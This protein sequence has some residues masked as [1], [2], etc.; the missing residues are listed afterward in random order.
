MD[1]NRLIGM[2]ETQDT[3]AAQGRGGRSPRWGWA[4]GWLALMALGIALV[5][6][7]AG[8]SPNLFT[9]SAVPTDRLVF[10]SLGD[11]KTF[12]PVMSNESPNVFSYITRGLTTQNGITGEVEPELAE[13]WDITNDGRT[14]TFTL[15]P[16]LRWSD[17][18][19]LTAE[20]VVFT[21]N[22][23]IF[24]EEIPTSSRDVL[25]IGTQ[26]LLPTV[27]QVGD[28]QVQFTLP[29]PF[30][31]FL[32][33]TG[34]DILPA[35][36]LRPTLEERD[37]DGNLR[38][39]STWGTSTPPEQVV[40][41]GPYKLLRYIPSERIIFERNPEYWR[42]GPDGSDQPYIQQL[43]WQIIESTDNALL[44]FRSGG[45]DLTGVTPDSFALLKREEERGNFTIYNGGPAT[46]TLFMAFNLNRASRNGVPLVDPIKSRWF[47][48]V[49]FRQ[50]VSYAINRDALINNVYQGL[51]EPQT[52]PISVQS[53][54]YAGPED[55]IRTYEH[56]VEK[57]R[58]LLEGDGFQWNAAG[59]LLD[60]QGNRV[61]FTLITNAGNKIRE[62]VGAQIRQDLAQLGMQV[63]FQPIAFNTLV[64][65]LTDGLDW[66]AHIL[67]LTGG[68][69]PNN[70]FN[71]WALDGSL[72]AFNQQA[73]PGQTPLEGWQAADW[74]ERIANL[75]IQGAQTVDE[76]ER[77]AIY[78]ETQQ[79]TQEYLPFI[80]LVN[81]LS[82]GAVRNK[83]EGVDYSALGGALWNIHELRLSAE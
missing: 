70:G 72:H 82:L 30:A 49:P 47:N 76:A 11:P 12:N 8:C 23:V 16:D 50:A 10:S 44:Q 14:I 15:R 79:L 57:A 29:E 38:F 73:Q 7:L 9:R 65:R 45:L 58:E 54:Y 56:D 31:P 3:M 60:D 34:I 18:E 37:G 4:G 2:Q 32:R 20:D 41:N 63:D 81:Q 61:R 59:E 22:E 77:R 64:D 40:V 80:Y 35:H 27:T 55:G 78:F 13:S 25:R 24:N 68:I 5:W 69:E 51:G 42:Q 17:G 53:P 71:V 21:Y 33:T 48:S 19:P 46:G 83:V 1:G 43:V 74:E 62:S 6:P 26:G 66:E 36:I 75:Y 52:S 67:G 28:R 39:L